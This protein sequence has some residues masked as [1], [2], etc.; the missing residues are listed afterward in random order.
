MPERRRC[1][2]YVDSEFKHVTRTVISDYFICSVITVF[3]IEY[4]NFITPNITNICVPAFDKQHN[5]L[6]YIIAERAY[7]KFRITHS[8]CVS[9]YKRLIKI[10]KL[11]TLVTVSNIC[12]KLWLLKVYKY[13]ILF[14]VPTHVSFCYQI[15]TL[16]TLFFQ[17]LSKIRTIFNCYFSTDT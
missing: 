1:A 6:I 8:F 14:D 11:F 5:K 15:P 4:R 17:N 3:I 12:V 16:F 10:D 13:Q 2:G 9:V 7:I